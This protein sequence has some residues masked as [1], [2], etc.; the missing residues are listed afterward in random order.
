MTNFKILNHIHEL[1]QLSNWELSLSSK[2]EQKLFNEQGDEV[3]S[4]FAGRQYR[5]YK[6]GH[7]TSGWEKF[8]LA[9]LIIFTLGIALASKY[10]FK[11]FIKGRETKNFAVCINDGDSQPSAQKG[12]ERQGRVANVDIGSSYKIPQQL[13]SALQADLPNMAILPQQVAATAQILSDVAEKAKQHGL[14]RFSYFLGGRENFERLPQLDLS[15]LGT[16]KV[17]IGN[18]L[19][20][21]RPAWISGNYPDSIPVEVLQNIDADVIRGVNGLLGYEYLIVKYRD[22]DTIPGIY[23]LFCHNDTGQFGGCKIQGARGA[24]A[25]ES[26]VID[27]LTCKVEDPSNPGQTMDLSSRDKFKLLFTEGA[28]T[29]K[30]DN[31]K[32]LVTVSLKSIKRILD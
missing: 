1:D 5:L 12:K 16:K 7:S 14:E 6:R 29:G 19:F 13:T 30:N 23:V 18:G 28:V 15:T 8:S 4:T 24:T 20:I 10:V 27:Y 25:L 22:I 21:D 9:L 31:R 32:E 3:P 11:A 26:S 17:F 2:K